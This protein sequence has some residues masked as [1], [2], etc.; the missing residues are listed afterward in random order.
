MKS[1]R[2]QLIDKTYKESWQRRSIQFMFIEVTRHEANL[3]EEQKIN[4]MLH[5]ACHHL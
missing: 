2:K 3:Q 5:A 1:K 4:C